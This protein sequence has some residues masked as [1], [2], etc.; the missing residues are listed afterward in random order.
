MTMKRS[1]HPK[2][3][4]KFKQ[5]FSIKAPLQPCPLC[6]EQGFRL[7][8]GGLN[9]ACDPFIHEINLVDNFITLICDLATRETKFFSYGKQTF[10]TAAMYEE[11]KKKCECNV[12]LNACSCGAFEKEME[13]KNA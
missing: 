11:P 4:E 6:G 2:D 13:E 1:R 9:G 8:R 12:W 7:E 5:Y 3:L 10:L